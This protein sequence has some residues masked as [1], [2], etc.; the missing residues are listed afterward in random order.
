MLRASSNELST[1][2]FGEQRGDI[3]A[4]LTHG[5]IPRHIVLGGDGSNHCFDSAPR[6]DELPHSCADIIEAKQ[7]LR[8]HVV[9][10]RVVAG[11]RRYDGGRDNDEIIRAQRRGRGE[12]GHM[13]NE[14]ST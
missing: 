5:R 14:I 3:L 6:I 9:N 1:G 12:I 8:D 2:Q 7:L 13:P 11:A 4:N 10:E